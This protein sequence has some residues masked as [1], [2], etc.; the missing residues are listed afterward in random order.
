VTAAQ[1]T[2]LRVSPTELLSGASTP[3]AVSEYDEA[4]ASPTLPPNA[5]V[6]ITSPPG[7]KSKPYGV[8]PLAA[9]VAG[10][11]ARPSASTVYVL[12]LSVP[13]SVTTSVVP[14]ALKAI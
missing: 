7:V 2:S 10:P 8:F 9:I 14:S 6:T 5:S 4:A 13:R 12:M 1:Q 3:G 11:V